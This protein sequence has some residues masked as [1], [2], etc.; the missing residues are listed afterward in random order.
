MRFVLFWKR[1]LLLAGLLLL[2][3]V[4]TAVAQ[5]DSPKAVEIRMMS[6]NIWVGGELVDFG[7]VVEAIKAA[8]ADIVGLQ[9]A[10]GNTRRLAQALGWSYASERMQIIS[11]FPL[12]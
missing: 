12:I 5:T 6:F 9:E 11:R 7:Q 10:G 1:G 4:T 2:L 3:A 8:K